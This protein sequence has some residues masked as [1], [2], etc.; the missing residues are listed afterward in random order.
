MF[1][2]SF[3]CNYLGKQLSIESASTKKE[4]EQGTV[5]QN[6]RAHIKECVQT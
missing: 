2:F 6:Y 3:A 4:C 1:Q 5:T